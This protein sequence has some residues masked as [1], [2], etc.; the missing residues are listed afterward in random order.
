LGF[1]G[2]R[3]WCGFFIHERGDGFFCSFKK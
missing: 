2:D 1:V 3:S